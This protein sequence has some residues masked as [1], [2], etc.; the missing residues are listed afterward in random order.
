[1]PN[2]EQWNR[3]YLYSSKI[4]HLQSLLGKSTSRHSISQN[5]VHTLSNPQHTTGGTLFPSLRALGR[6]KAKHEDLDIT[7][8]GSNEVEWAT[9]LLQPSLSDVC[10]HVNQYHLGMIGLRVS[11]NIQLEHDRLS[12]AVEKLIQALSIHSPG[13]RHLDICL[14]IPD[15]ICLSINRSLLPS[16]LRS[17]QQ[18]E[19]LRMSRGLR[20]DDQLLASLVT[21]PLLR[22]MVLASTSDERDVIVTRDGSFPQLQSLHMATH[23]I[24]RVRR[25]VSSAPA[26]Q[27][28]SAPLTGPNGLKDTLDWL[29]Q[30]S[31]CLK[32][33]ELYLSFFDTPLP[34][35]ELQI[36]A[37]FS[38]ISELSLIYGRTLVDDNGVKILA[39]GLP[40]L[41]R[42]RLGNAAGLDSMTRPTNTS[43]TLHSIHTL[44]WNCP[45]LISITIDVDARQP[46]DIDAPGYFLTDRIELNLLRSVINDPVLV[47]EWMRNCFGGDREII[48]A[49]D[50]D[51]LPSP[52]DEQKE[53]R[54]RWAKVTELLSGR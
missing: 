32:E 7:A 54:L 41:C 6:I 52:N 46:P 29:Y 47:A 39:R 35:A 48:I 34:A 51:K 10:V 27:S 18:L 22:T 2:V 30:A 42:I 5:A 40:N 33:I 17:L 13:I 28:I 21:L 53:M 12:S 9:Q 36:L 15:P 38:N 25:S 19:T 31:P 1:M 24:E 11:G 3:F 20:I 4:R 8:S 44:S 16:C 45:L 14:S 26:L 50:W 23:N 49:N 43:P 37:G